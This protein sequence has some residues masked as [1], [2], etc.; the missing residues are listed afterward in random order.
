MVGLPDSTGY[1]AW[2]S[3]GPTHRAGENFSN[4]TKIF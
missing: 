3:G 1:T 2:A 4:E